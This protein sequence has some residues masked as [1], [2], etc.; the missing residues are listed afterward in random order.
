MQGLQAG[1]ISY[2][3]KI[4]HRPE[5]NQPCGSGRPLGRRG[6]YHATD[7]RSSRWVEALQSDDKDFLPIAPKANQLIFIRGLRIDAPTS[8]HPNQYTC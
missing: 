1:N 3:G 5:R 2:G 4:S 7:V 6:Y 8:S